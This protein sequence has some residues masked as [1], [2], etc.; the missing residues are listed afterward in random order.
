MVVAALASNDPDAPRAVGFIS[1]EYAEHA[2]GFDDTEARHVL[3][4]ARTA[5]LLVQAEQLRRTD[6][7]HRRRRRTRMRLI[8]LSLIHI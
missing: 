8:E 6:N 2:G 3:A 7:E 1:A 4:M 5:G